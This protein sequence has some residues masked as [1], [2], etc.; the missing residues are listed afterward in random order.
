VYQYDY[1]GVFFLDVR[2][3]ARISRF[4]KIQLKDVDALHHHLE[5]TDMLVNLLLA[6]E[7]KVGRLE[8]PHLFF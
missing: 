4:W 8:R 7:D 5:S 1:I 6:Y 3:N 2:A